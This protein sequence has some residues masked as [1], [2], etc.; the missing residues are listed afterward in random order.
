M[1]A[2]AQLERKDPCGT[3][4]LIWFPSRGDGWNRLLLEPQERRCALLLASFASSAVGSQTTAFNGGGSK[5]LRTG[6]P[7]A[8]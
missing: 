1:A 2:C 7:I 8:M 5:R 4:A 6:A 3:S